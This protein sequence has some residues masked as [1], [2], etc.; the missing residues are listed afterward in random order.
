MAWILKNKRQDHKRLMAICEAAIN[1]QKLIQEKEGWIFFSAKAPSEVSAWMRQRQ[2][3]DRNALLE[4]KW[5][6]NSL[7]FGSPIS[8]IN[9]RKMRKQCEIINNIWAAKLEAIQ[10]KDLA[11]FAT[12]TGEGSAERKKALYEKHAME[13][14][15]LAEAVANTYTLWGTD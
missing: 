6:Y 8:I 3:A 14:A 12:D 5:K 9:A 1:H 15:H 4:L 7:S 2:E 11:V 10:A 13:K